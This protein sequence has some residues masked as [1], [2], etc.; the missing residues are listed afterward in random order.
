MAWPGV[1]ALLIPS[2]V[3]EEEETEIRSPKRRY[4][5][6]GKGPQE[7]QYKKTFFFVKCRPWYLSVIH[8]IVAYH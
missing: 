7:V 8:I 1:H 3:K 5:G 2:G 4:S 6:E